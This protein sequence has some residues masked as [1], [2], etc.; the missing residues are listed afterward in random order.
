MET[1]S[2]NP[3]DAPQNRLSIVI[4]SAH[5]HM[6]QQI[7]GAQS[8]TNDLAMILQSLGHEVSVLAAL[9]DDRSPLTLRAQAASELG[10][11]YVLDDD[12]G[13]TCF[14]TFSPAR[15]VSDLVRQ[16]RPDVF[17]VQSMDAV[18]LGRAVNRAGIPLVFYFR[19]TLS[20]GTRPETLKASFVSNSEFTARYYLETHGISSEVVPPLVRRERYD[21]G[22]STGS[23]VLF[24]NPIEIKGLSIALGLA[25]RCPDIPFVF[26]EG[27]GLSPS[28]H[29]ALLHELVTLPNVSLLSATHDVKAMYARARLVLAPSRWEEAWGRVATEAHING[30]PVLGSKIGGLPEA[31][32]PGGMVVDPRSPI[33]AWESALRAMWFDELAYARLS[34]EATTFS[35]RPMME[36]RRQAEALLA[37][38]DA[39]ITR[40]GSHLS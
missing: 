11:P 4:A 35:L 24:I 28:E 34:D 13:Y 29:A 37:V 40:V 36:P 21:F 22:G 9:N 27:W 15:A 6:P 1:K 17:I 20:E 7:G 8:S 33:E 12:L 23:S 16:L 2:S 25:R 14:R 26:V 3:S 31:I 18:D 39:E 38:I 32:G 5:A 10:D 30:I 19:N